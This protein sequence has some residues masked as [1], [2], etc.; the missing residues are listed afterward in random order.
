VNFFNVVAG[1]WD[2]WKGDGVEIHYLP[3]HRYNLEEVGEAL[4]AAR[5]WY[6]EWFHPYPWKDLRL[7]EF[8]GLAGY[9][10]GFPTNITFSENIG[11]LTRS[12]P[13]AAVAFLVTAHEVAH[14]WWGNILLPGDG[15]GGNVLSEGM[16]HFSTILLH[17]QVKGV[18]ERIEFCKGIEDRYGDRRQVDSEKPLAWVDGSKG[19]DETVMY[20]KGGWAAWMLLNHM[21]REANLVGLRDFIGRY[22]GNPDHPVIQDFTR[23][24]REHAADPA[25]YDAFVQQWYYEV[26]LPSYRVHD[27]T[28]RGSGTS[29][30]VTATVE[31][32]GTGRMPVDVAVVAGERWP[33][34]DGKGTKPA[35][36]APAAGPS[37]KPWHEARTTV[38]LGA[39]EKAAVTIETAFEPERV[40]L[41]PDAKVLMLKREKAEAKL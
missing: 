19:G 41:D 10:Q 1:R 25:A 38:V 4:V 9:A 7:N 8:A 13:E 28:K 32:A 22:H 31:N 17:E 40:L 26:V 39:G 20:D 29:W 35:R 16:A 18:R 15:P 3:A 2:V 6:S 33:D 5:R 27:A 12:K 21:G 23:V 34:A 11:F 30:T 36:D 14:Q 37:A 24:M